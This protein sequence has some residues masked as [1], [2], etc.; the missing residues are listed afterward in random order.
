MNTEHD[1][2][3]KLND[4]VLLHFESF[5]RWEQTFLSETLNKVMYKQPV[6]DKQKLLV[7]KIINK[8]ADIR[9][10]KLNRYSKKRS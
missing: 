10:K 4:A 5:S 8:Y 6:S 7:M 1:F 9:A 2:F 3:T